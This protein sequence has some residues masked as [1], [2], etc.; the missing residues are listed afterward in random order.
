[1]SGSDQ[2]TNSQTP[3]KTKKE[4]SGF[5]SPRSSKKTELLEAKLTVLST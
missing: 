5:L 3:T 4:K 1:M 2:N